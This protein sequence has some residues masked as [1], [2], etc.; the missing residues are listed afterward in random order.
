MLKKT[1]AGNYQTCSLRLR[2]GF[3]FLLA[4]CA[5]A[6]TNRRYLFLL[7]VVR[8]PFGRAISVPRIAMDER[9]ASSEDMNSRYAR[10]SSC[11]EEAG[12]FI[13]Y[14]QSSSFRVARAD[15]ANGLPSPDGQFQ[16]EVLDEMT[17]TTQYRWPSALIHVC[18]SCIDLGS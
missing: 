4:D 15:P 6:T 14:Y 11:P 2:Y 1:R 17:R 18:L 8:Q 16:F 13:S 12:E 5:A 9:G 3:N 10:S 7:N